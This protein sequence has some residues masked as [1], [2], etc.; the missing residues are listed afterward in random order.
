MR[1]PCM[2]LRIHLASF[3]CFSSLGMFVH[4][5]ST[6]SY[7]LSFTFLKKGNLGPSL[8]KYYIEE[9]IVFNK[10]LKHGATL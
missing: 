10:S 4:I 8:K 1:I 3:S 5:L 2:F 6:Y 7:A 9:N